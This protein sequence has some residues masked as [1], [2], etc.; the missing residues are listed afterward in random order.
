MVSGGKNNIASGDCAVVVGGDESTASGTRA[1]VSGGETNAAGGNYS[2]IGGGASNGASGTGATIGGGESNLAS[3]NHATVG[4]GSGNA[5]GGIRATISGGSAN[6]TSESYASIGGGRSNTAN[7]QYTTISGGYANVVIADYG[8]IGGGG[9]SNSEDPFNTSNFVTDEFGTIGGGANNMA[10]DDDGTTTDMTYATVGGG[11]AN[12]ATNHAATVGGGTG[13]TAT[14]WIATVAGG[15]GNDATNSEAT[16]GGGVFNT[17]SGMASTVP[18]GAN[19]TAAGDFSFAAGRNAYVQGAHEGTFVFADSTN[20]TFA[21]IGDDMFSVRASGGVE[22]FTKSDLGS[23]VTMAAGASAW[24]VVSAREAKENF[25]PVDARDVL[26]K[27]VAMPIETWN[28]KSQDDTVRH[29]GPM[30][31]DFQEAFGVGDFPK[32]ITTID[33]DGVALAAIQGLN[34]KLEERDATIR[35]LTRAVAALTARLKAVEEAG[36]QRE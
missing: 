22:F 5:A 21:S 33:A 6:T 9:P 15:W 3:S 26:E 10:G 30:A 34:Q 18:G 19:N 1:T 24:S 17:A 27:V 23:G 4:G 31:D 29:I 16:V 8:T 14:G 7:A 32:R 12:Q 13:N 36:E 28:Y 2:S 20:S 25:V 11:H 35:A